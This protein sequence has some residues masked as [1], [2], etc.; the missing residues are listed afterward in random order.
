M[1]E[2]NMVHPEDMT[3]KFSLSPKLHLASIMFEEL[4][5][6]SNEYLTQ[7]VVYLFLAPY[8]KVNY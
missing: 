6:A 5:K 8:L 3:D 2:V 4:A 7:E 1:L